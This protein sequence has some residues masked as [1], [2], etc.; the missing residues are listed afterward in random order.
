ME[1]IQCLPFPMFLWAMWCISKEYVNVTFRIKM[2]GHPQ[3]T[4]PSTFITTLDLGRGS[5]IWGWHIYNVQKLFSVKKLLFSN[6]F[7]QASCPFCCVSS[8]KRPYA[9][10]QCSHIFLLTLEMTAR[11]TLK[12][13]MHTIW[14]LTA[15]VWWQEKTNIII[16]MI[17]CS[18]DQV[19]Q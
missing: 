6:L 1:A 14:A 11:Q 9:N 13:S 12:I 3:M 4:L 10:R 2:A 15:A 16:H 5:R 18:H 19:G 8:G 17:I 7:R